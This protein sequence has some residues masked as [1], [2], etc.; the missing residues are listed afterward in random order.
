[1]EVHPLR[2]RLDKPSRSLVVDWSDG[3]RHTFPWPLLRSRCPSAT[4]RAAREL[5]DKN[6]LAVL[7]HVP[8]S[9]L[10][11]IRP[12]GNYAINLVWSDGHAAGIYTWEY[13]LKISGDPRVH[14]QGIA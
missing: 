12:V 13:L 6:P 10:T 1:M 11:E 2:I 5:A 7:D 14:S 3:V 9:D 4:E 8:S